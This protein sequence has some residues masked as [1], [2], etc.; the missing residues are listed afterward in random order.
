MSDVCNFVTAQC[1]S[2]S[3]AWIDVLLAD[4]CIRQDCSKEEA[5]HDFADRRAERFRK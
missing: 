2:R 3:L 5:S 1:I 4:R